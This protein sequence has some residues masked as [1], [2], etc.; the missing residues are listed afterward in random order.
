MS[1]LT[2]AMRYSPDFY[3]EKGASPLQIENAEKVLELKFAPDFKECLQE[4]GAVSLAGHE[5]TGFSTD[6][7]LD[8]VEVT[9]KNWKKVTSVKSLYVIEETHIDGIVIWQDTNGAIYETAT[10]SNTKKI[11]DSLAEY[12]NII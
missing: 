11:A 7:S 1:K 10:N 6:K 9:K 2:E 3:A 12:L 8:V 4:F 5:L